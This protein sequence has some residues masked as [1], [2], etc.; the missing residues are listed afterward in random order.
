MRT[1]RGLTRVTTDRS[2]GKRDAYSDTLKLST[3]SMVY[4]MYVV[5]TMLWF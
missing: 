5:E 3:A 4:V 2:V 1:G